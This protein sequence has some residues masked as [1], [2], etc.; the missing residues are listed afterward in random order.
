MVKPYSN[1]LRARVVRAV[2]E[3]A[4]CRA[5][6]ARFGV[7]VSTA[8][9]WVQRWRRTGS[10]RPQPQ[11]GDNRSRRLE[12][13]AAEILALVGETPD[14]TLAEIA[15][16]LLMVQRLG[17][18]GVHLADAG[19]SVRAARKELGA[20]AI[21]GAYCGS[22]RH[23]GMGAGEAGADYVSF[24]PVQSGALGDGSVADT[25]L[26]QWWSDMIEVPVVAEGD[27]DEA[28]MARLSP[29]TDFF[30]IGDEI[31]GQPDPVQA[32]GTLIAAT[33]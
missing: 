24:G 28:S 13:H 19:R 14:I 1:D 32:L 25:D 29:V 12:A 6:A 9:K 16:H 30:G 15:D 27:L 31:W 17:L 22:S 7:A 5:A 21:V 10:V 8:I 18:D 3:G 2:D 20:D 11:G 4:S 33:S 23:D 26:F